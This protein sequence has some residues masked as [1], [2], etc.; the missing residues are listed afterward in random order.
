MYINAAS[1][2]YLANYDLAKKRNCYLRKYKKIP[3]LRIKESIKSL[4]EKV[5]R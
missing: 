4:E 2:F 3:I 1:E 5:K